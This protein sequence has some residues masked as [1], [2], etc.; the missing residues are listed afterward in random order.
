ML[1]GDKAEVSKNPDNNSGA[2]FRSSAP[3]NELVRVEIN[4]IKLTK[5]K[6]YTPA[7]EVLS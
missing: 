4:G 1:E 6:D 7:P 5:D 3:L 2:V